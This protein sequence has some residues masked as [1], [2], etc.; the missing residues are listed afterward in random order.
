VSCSASGGIASHQRLNVAKDWFRKADPVLA[1]GLYLLQMSTTAGLDVSLNLDGVASY[2]IHVSS[3]LVSE[4]LQERSAI[5]DESSS[6][7]LVDLLR[8]Q[9]L[10]DQDVRGMDGDAYELV[11]E[12]ACEQAGVKVAHGTGA[13]AAPSRCVL[14]GPVGRAGPHF[15]DR[16]DR[17]NTQYIVISSEERRIRWIR[18]PQAPPLLVFVC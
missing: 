3:N 7:G 11:I 5:L 18:Q 13:A 6:R 4:M 8:A 14:G 17:R 9:E 15:R 16:Q 10:S 2:L 12:K 1:I